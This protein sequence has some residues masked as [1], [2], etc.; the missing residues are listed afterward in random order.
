MHLPIILLQSEEQS[1]SGN[2]ETPTREI[3]K[4]NQIRDFL[5]AVLENE[6]ARQIYL[7]NKATL[8][9]AYAIT[10]PNGRDVTAFL[11]NTIRF[12]SQFEGDDLA[13]DI[14]DKERAMIQ[15]VHAFTGKIL[16]QTVFC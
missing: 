15:K 3:L 1:I 16:Q 11:K 6:K 2:P 12:I 8:S 10:Q 14:T 7:N 13:L 9:D 5:P 4:A